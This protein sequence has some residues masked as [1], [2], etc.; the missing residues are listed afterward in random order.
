LQSA[1]KATPDNQKMMEIVCKDVHMGTHLVED[2]LAN[3][4]AL[5]KRI[6][7]RY[8]ALLGCA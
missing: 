8:V 6:D 5:A 7:D 3:P 2:L 4:A 1:A